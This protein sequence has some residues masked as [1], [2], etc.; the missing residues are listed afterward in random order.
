MT[1]Y[2]NKNL[3]KCSHREHSNQNYIT[4]VNFNKDLKSSSI[5]DAQYVSKQRILGGILTEVVVTE[6]YLYAPFSGGEKGAR[7]TVKTRLVYVETSK[8]TVQSKCSVPKKILFE[9]ARSVGA[10][11][12]NAD[13]ILKRVETFA[14]KESNWHVPFEKT[15]A[16][17]FAELV[18]TVR[19]AQRE[20][21]VETFNKFAVTE[22]GQQWT[23]F[24]LSLLF[25]A[26]TQESVAA[27][28]N[29]IKNKKLTPSEEKQAY[30]S[31]T[32]TQ[33]T[34][35]AAFAIATVSI[36]GIFFSSKI[37]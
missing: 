27:V 2:R 4:S 5:L 25:S 28:L 1:V 9:N 37:F 22:Y 19:A 17:E 16:K 20:D 13:G 34:D 10:E 18:R 35:P 21:L 12:I 29:L 24:Y 23:E 3:N 32:F 30:L 14:R 26:R 7:A 8:E 31:L 15:S 11:K 6:N 33:H 36:F